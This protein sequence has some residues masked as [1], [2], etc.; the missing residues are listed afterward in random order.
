[1]AFDETGVD[2]ADDVDDAV[3]FLRREPALVVTVAVVDDNDNVA[4]VVVGS[5]AVD[6]SKCMIVC[7]KE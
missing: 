2:A 3:D 7:E 5:T 4:A 1:M 6:D